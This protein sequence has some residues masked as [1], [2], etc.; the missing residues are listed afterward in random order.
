MGIFSV[1]K[2]GE[3]EAFLRCITNEK[4]RFAGLKTGTRVTFLGR[5]VLLPI[6]IETEACENRASVYL[7]RELVVGERRFPLPSVRS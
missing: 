7:K 6:S 2:E 5:S 4:G 1:E 3:Y